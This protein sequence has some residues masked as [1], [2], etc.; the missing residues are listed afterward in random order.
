MRDKVTVIGLGNMGAALASALVKSGREVTVWNRTS[1]KAAP[2]VAEGAR[3][4][5]TIADAIAASDVIVICVFSY[6]NAE[7]A[8]ADV[9]NS[10]HLLRGGY[11]V[12]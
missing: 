11:G 8:L 4:A 2:L 5:P 1:A 10:G 12:V 9:V 7:A 3:L 6:D